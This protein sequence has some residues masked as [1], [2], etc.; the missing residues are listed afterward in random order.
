MTDCT[1]ANDL[2]KPENRI[3]VLKDHHGRDMIDR[4]T[5]GVYFKFPDDLHGAEL[6]EKHYK[7]WKEKNDTESKEAR[8]FALTY[9]WDIM[10]KLWLSLFE[11]EAA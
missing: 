7:L 10:A 8:Q 2:C 3:R 1:T 9:D 11:K 4:G 5:N 6:L